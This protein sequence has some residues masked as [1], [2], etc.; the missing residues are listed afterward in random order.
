MSMSLEYKTVVAASRNRARLAAA[1]RRY[2]DPRDVPVLLADACDD[3]GW[4]V[5]AVE[6]ARKETQDGVYYKE[7]NGKPARIRFSMLRP[8]SVNSVLHELAHH[9]LGGQERD[10][11]WHGSEFVATLDGLLAWYYLRLSEGGT[12]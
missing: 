8:M 5:P 10:H 11:R 9:A 12:P 3:H 4:S 2:L 6:W 7:Q 1:R